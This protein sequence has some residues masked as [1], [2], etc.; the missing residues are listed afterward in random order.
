MK[1]EKIESVVSYADLSNP[2]TVL[3]MSVD[4]DIFESCIGCEKKAEVS[5]TERRDVW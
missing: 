4:N 5:S 2:H 1:K 3:N